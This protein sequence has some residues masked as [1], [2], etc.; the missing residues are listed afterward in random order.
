MT[1]GGGG[2]GGGEGNGIQRMDLS[3]SMED[4]VYI[5]PQLPWRLEVIVDMQR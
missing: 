1:L 3:S 4:R 5:S 2:G